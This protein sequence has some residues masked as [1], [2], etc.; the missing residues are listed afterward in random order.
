MENP[1]SCPRAREL[2]RRRRPRCGRC[3]RSA[4][5]AA[6]RSGS[7]S[8]P[9][10]SPSS[11]WSATRPGGRPS[12]PRP[13]CRRGQ[14]FTL[15]WGGDFTPGSAYGRPPDR[16]RGMLG[17]VAGQLR[18]ADVAALNLE[19]TFGR[20]GPRSA[21]PASADVLRLPGAGPQ[22][23]RAG[24]RRRRHRQPRQQPR[25]G[26]RRQR[27]GQTVGAARRHGAWVTGRPGEITLVDLP[28]ARVAFVGFAAYPWASPIRD[29][30]AVRAL[31]AA[32]RPAGQRRRRAHARRRRG[33]RPGAT[34]DRDEE[35]FGELRGNP[36]A[37]AH[38]AVDAG[39]D[40]VLGSG[41]H[42]L[43]GMELYRG[44]L[45]RLLA[46]QPRR[47]PQ[48]LPARRLRAQ[49]AA[50]RPRRAARHVRRGGVHAA[51]PPQPGIPS[52][53]ASGAASR[54]V[55]RVGRLD[56][57]PRAVRHVVGPARACPGRPRLVAP[58]G[59]VLTGTRGLCKA[60]LGVRFPP[61]PCRAPG[62]PASPR[63]TGP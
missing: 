14:T 29:L 18:A 17:A 11:S 61:P 42:V 63:A 19:G 39:A 33:R 52:R 3:R 41:P 37:F 15:A 40:L 28:R 46:G 35:A 60:E 56:F 10:C 38:A 20:G 59:V 44:R 9:S 30:L 55:T 53:D 8:R 21:R 1:R 50:A 51:R 23:D 7:P 62:A 49:R 12:R 36:R 6:P 2:R 48:L 4:P 27:Q 57:G 13:R 16:A 47:L 32:R 22:R 54:L 58:G 25:L 34:P 45:D 24:R 26:L 31:V 5:P 43:R